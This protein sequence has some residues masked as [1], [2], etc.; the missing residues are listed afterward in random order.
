MVHLKRA[1]LVEAPDVSEKKFVLQLL[2]AEGEDKSGYLASLGSQLEH[3]EWIAALKKN[4]EFEESEAPQRV[5]RKKESVLNRAKK[6]MAG[7]AAT[8][9]LGKRVVKSIINEETTSLLSAMKRIVKK[10]SSQKKADEFEKNI[11]KI[12]VKSYLLI[13]NKKLTGDDFLEV[14]APLRESFELM[15][16]CFNARGRV[17]QQ[18]VLDA[19]KKVEASIKKAEHILTGLLSAHLTN[20]NMFR[21]TQTFGYLGNA[22]FLNK[23]FNDPALEG[24]VEKLVDAMEYYT[25]FHYHK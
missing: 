20:K 22:E 23:V 7:S 21:L 18:V 8:S 13:E 5:K 10:E 24:E 12:A 14:D 16:K 15:I 4:K 17:Q 11:I 9:H 25:Q 2:V 19:L 3:T 1:T 6:K